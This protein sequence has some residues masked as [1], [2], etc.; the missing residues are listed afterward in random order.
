MIKNVL[1]IGA[2]GTVGF[3]DLKQLIVNRK[4]NITV[5]DVENKKFQKEIC[6]SATDF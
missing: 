5:F 4:Y 3:E 2:S 1:L 6:I